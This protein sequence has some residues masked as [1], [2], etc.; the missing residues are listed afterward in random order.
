MLNTFIT[1]CD[2][3]QEWMLPWFL[4]NFFKHNPTANIK[5]VD[6][7]LSQKGIDHAAAYG[8]KITDK[9]NTNIK[10]WFYKP[11][12]IL[13]IKAD[14]KIWL[15]VDCEVRGNLNEMFDL[16]LESKLSM[17][18]DRPWSRRRGELW[19]NSGV[20]GVIHNPPILKL[21]SQRCISQNKV[22]DQEVLQEML[23]DPLQ[24][25]IYINEVSSEYNFLRLDFLDGLTDRNAKIVHW[26]GPKGKIKIREMMNG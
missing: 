7:G 19:Y 26:T 11:K 14:K 20:V 8:I 23:S 2:A 16:L 3:Q 6:F 22:G 25:L 12:A 24:K 9:I 15:D 13:D 18:Q 1:G 21:W 4:S 17:C 10:A 5:V